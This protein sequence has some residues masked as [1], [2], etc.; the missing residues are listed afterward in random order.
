MRFCET[1]VVEGQFI[2]YLEFYLGKHKSLHIYK[3]CIASYIKICK[4]HASYIQCTYF[5]KK[6]LFNVHIF[7]VVRY[8][9]TNNFPIRFTYVLQS[10]F[11][12]RDSEISDNWLLLRMLNPLLRVHFNALKFFLLLIVLLLLVS[13][14][15]LFLGFNFFRAE[16]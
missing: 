14:F 12:L 8:S 13:K 10:V 3:W 9:T 1:E 6:F 16:K 7:W 2:V 4:C 15:Y 5:V 11:N